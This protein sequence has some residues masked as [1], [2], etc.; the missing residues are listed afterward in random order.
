ME[1]GQEINNSWH[2][3]TGK[4]RGREK[5]SASVEDAAGFCNCNSIAEKLLKQYYAVIQT[6]YIE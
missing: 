2:V 4:R 3:P 1:V 6:I 5:Y